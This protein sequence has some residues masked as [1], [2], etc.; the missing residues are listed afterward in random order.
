MLTRKPLLRRH[1]GALPSQ[2]PPDWWNSSG[3]YRARNCRTSRAAASVT[4]TRGG[5][6]ALSE[7]AESIGAVADQQVLGLLVVVHDHLVRFAT[8][9]GG[10]VAAERRVCRIHVVAVG[11]HAS[12]L[13]LAADPVCDGAIARPDARTQPVNR[14]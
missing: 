1:I 5:A 6:A 11:P 12:G 8:E 2:Q 13:D 10:F 14:V 9:A 4:K 7:E 3:P